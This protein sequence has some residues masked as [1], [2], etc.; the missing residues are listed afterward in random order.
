M[1][2][3]IKLPIQNNINLTERLKLY[4]SIVRFSFNRYQDGLNQ[5]EIRVLVKS[6][7]PRSESW[8]SQNAILE[9][10]NYFDKNKDKNIVFGGKY[11]LLK[12]QHNKITKQE[13]K[14]LRLFPIYIQGE[15]V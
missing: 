11:N 6:K 3:T 9:G 15:T 14:D 12:R 2:I 7:F 10:K 5:K 1:I 8:F 13:W 4:N